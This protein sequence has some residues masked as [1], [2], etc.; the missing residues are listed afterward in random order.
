MK[1]VCRLAGAILL[2]LITA[3]LL[4]CQPDD[5]DNSSG[6]DD[7]SATGQGLA[8]TADFLN[9]KLSIVDIDKLTKGAT[10]ADALVGTVDLSNYSPGPLDLAITPDGKTALVSI[11]GGWLGSFT[12][13]PAGNGTLLFVDIP[14]RKVVAELFTGKSP[15][16]IAITKDGKRA[17]VG[18]YAESYFAVVDIA[19]RTYTKIQTGAQYNEEIALDDTET[20][21]ILSYGT[22]GNCRTFS[23][24]NPSTLGKTTG[25]SG[26]AAGVAFFPGTKVAYV[27]ESPT[28]LTLNAGGHVLVKVTNVSAPTTSNHVSSMQSPN[29]YPVTPLPSRKTVAIPAVKNGTLSLVEMKLNGTTA[30]QVQSITVGAV[31]KIAY[32]AVTDPSGRVLVAVPGEHFVGVIDL[33]SG[34]AFTV[35]WEVSESGPTTIRIVP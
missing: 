3:V 24:A 13:V 28:P 8:I 10:R 5:S 14:S 32:G 9:Q 4:S 7:T 15:M 27:V 2:M 1:K 22:S 16:G 18:H 23:V 19:A 25:I 21:G 20:V 31:E 17:F 12:T 30:Q 34:T 29:W 26:D 33:A 11:S 6:T 35:P